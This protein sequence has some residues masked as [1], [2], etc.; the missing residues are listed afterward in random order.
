MYG[1]VTLPI[2]VVSSMICKDSAKKKKQL[3]SS[4]ATNPWI[5]NYFILLQTY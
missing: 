3:V 1:L 5:G 4:R 2:F